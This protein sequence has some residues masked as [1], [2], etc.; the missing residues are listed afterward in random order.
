[1]RRRRQ[2]K[3]CGRRFTTYETF[4]LELRVTKRNGETEDF[5]RDKLLRVVEKVT[6]DRNVGR[7]T[8]E[9]LVRGLEAELSDG[10]EPVVSSATLAQKLYDRLVALDDLAAR[11]FAANYLAEDGSVRIARD[12][13]PQL[14][15]PA[16]ASPD[17][18]PPPPPRRRK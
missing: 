17:P 3:E 1:M 7:K 9:D 4:R 18:V 16:V 5:D 14:T 2:C 13:S 12:P 8:R 11:R 6:W 15:L 10:G